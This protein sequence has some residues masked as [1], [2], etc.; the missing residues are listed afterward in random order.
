M[1]A[2]TSARDYASGLLEAAVES[3]SAHF[4]ALAEQMDNNALLRRLSDPGQE[5]SQRRA[6]LA[7]LLP[8]GLGKLEMNLL[9][10]LLLRGDLDKLRAV[11][12]ELN[13][14]VQ[15]TVSG[16]Q[17]AEITTA[18]PLSDDD[19][20]AL[21]EKLCAQFGAG[22]E[23]LYREDPA[24]LGGMIVRVGDKLIDTSVSGRLNRM[25][26]QLVAAVR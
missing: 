4:D 14:L 3:W 22:L 11:V 7:G 1:K 16:V 6:A 21:Q 26:E 9:Q 2:E 23:F 17:L 10:T 20:Q 19:R 13:A 12:M 8:A 25:R 5:F 18:Q 15:R 24:I